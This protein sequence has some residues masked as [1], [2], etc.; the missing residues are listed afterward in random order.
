MYDNL[1]LWHVDS[2]LG[3]DRERSNYTI[4]FDQPVALMYHSLIHLRF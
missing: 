2:L 1:A 3:N 4:I